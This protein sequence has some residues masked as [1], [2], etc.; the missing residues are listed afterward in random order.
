[1][2]WGSQFMTHLCCPPNFPES[3][4]VFSTTIGD[5]FTYLSEFSPKIPRVSWSNLTETRICFIHGVGEKNHQL[6]Q[7]ILEKNTGFTANQR[8]GWI[9][10]WH[11]PPVK[12]FQPRWLGLCFRH[13]T[14]STPAVQTQGSREAPLYHR[15]HQWIESR[16][17]EFLEKTKRFPNTKTSLQV[18]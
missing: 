14:K 10:G 8:P 13:P 2:R 3:K 1:M 6:D 5:G 18:L 7:Q 9:D 11:F 16:L 12:F 17:S 4:Q 15:W